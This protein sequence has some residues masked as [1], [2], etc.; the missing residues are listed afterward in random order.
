MLEDHKATVQALRSALQKSEQQLRRAQEAA[1]IGTWEWELLENTVTWSKQ[2]FLI[3]QVP[4]DATPTVEL[5]RDVIH[6]DDLSIYDE[7]VMSIFAKSNIPATIQ[8]RVNRPDGQLRTLRVDA[9]VDYDPDG[10]PAR[11][12]GTV[13]DITTQLRT[14]VAL[15]QS[16]EEQKEMQAALQQ[17]E[18]RL[19]QAQKLEAIGRIAGG[20][21]HDF[22]NVLCAITVNAEYSLEQPNATG[23]VREA[24]QEIVQAAS[25][26]SK[27]T[28]QLL[29][30]SR[31]QVIKPKV[32]D[33]C[34]RL[35]SQYSMLRRLIGEDIILTTR[36][37]SAS[38]CVKIDPTQFEQVVLNLAVN[39]RDAMPQGGN[40]IIELEEDFIGSQDQAVLIV[41]D[42]GMGMAPDIREKIFDPFFT[43]KEMGRGTGLGL[44]TVH[45]IV[46]QNG[47]RI[48][49]YSQP[50]QG[51]CFKVF[52]PRVFDETDTISDLPTVA[53]V[54]G[55]ET[56]LLVE[57][58][59]TVRKASVNLLSQ[60][61]YTV[62]AAA[63]GRQALAVASSYPGTID[64]LVTDVIMPRMNGREL[65]TELTQRL[66]GLKV[67]FTSGY[68]AEV[69]G[70]RGVLDK[71]LNF[72]AKPYAQG[73]LGISVRK[74][75]DHEPE[76]VESVAH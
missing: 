76:S 42:S 45:G 32:I 25:Q 39:A 28:Q 41:T 20:I 66:P 7:T 50:G 11:L 57:D 13:Q 31:K 33:V 26:A 27:I 23:S 55:T 37:H 12:V 75:L 73:S 74:V 67:L 59:D 70:T 52:F 63:S 24:L 62:L 22:N 14:E 38:I 46:E 35:L 58:E 47:G 53:G 56:I 19:R 36:T 1:Q 5:I 71:G 65:A 8:F 18:D 17:S 2:T 61:G 34:C 54:G 51:T 68:T 48:E 10:N 16:E 6:P 72:I 4:L 64:L 60:S 15:R 9:Q 29:T 30:F 40:L 49:V 43:T 69:I 3:Y 21:A 44:A